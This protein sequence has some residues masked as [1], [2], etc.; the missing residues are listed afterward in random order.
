MMEYAS[1]ALNEKV[2]LYGE[3]SLYQ[4]LAEGK[5]NDEVLTRFEVTHAV[6]FW[7]LVESNRQQDPKRKG[8]LVQ[9]VVLFDVPTSAAV[10]PALPRGPVD[11]GRTYLQYGETDRRSYLG[12]H[13]PSWLER[14]EF[15]GSMAVRCTSS[16]SACT[17]SASR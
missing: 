10:T 1:Q 9:S 16:A 4:Q 5:R 12:T 6:V 13:Q 2:A 7:G 14:P 8:L 11:P 15:G 3:R 17:A